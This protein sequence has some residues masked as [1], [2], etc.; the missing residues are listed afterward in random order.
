MRQAGSSA[1][2]ASG[3][4]YLLNNQANNGSWNNSVFQTAL[5]VESLYTGQ[6]SADLAISSSDIAFNPISV[7]TVP[8][9]VT[10]SA[11]VRNLGSQSVSQAKVSFYSGDPSLGNLISQ[12]TVD[13]AGNASSLV[14]TTI[15][16]TDLQPS[17]YYVVVDE[18]NLVA[19]ASEWNNAAVKTLASGPPPALGFGPF[20]LFGARISRSRKCTAESFI[21]LAGANYCVL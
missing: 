19:E 18:A 6:V 13:I 3:V 14:E 17:S 21:S 8:I 16:V 1:G 4:G 20:L 10:I 12:S 2:T 11:T 5:A 7:E 15:T 9:D